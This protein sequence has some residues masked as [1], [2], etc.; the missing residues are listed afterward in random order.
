M[1]NNDTYNVYCIMSFLTERLKTMTQNTSILFPGTLNNPEMNCGKGLQMN[2][3]Q[4]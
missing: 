2:L 1:G 3:S 4:S